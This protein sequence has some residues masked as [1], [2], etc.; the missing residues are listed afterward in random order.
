MENIPT[1]EMVELKRE[2]LRSVNGGYGGP[3]PG[4]IAYRSHALAD[5]F[6]GVK[7]GLSSIWK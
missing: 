5:F 6:R 1:N 7:D 3:P 2:E 4:G